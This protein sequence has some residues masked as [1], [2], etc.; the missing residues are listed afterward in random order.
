MTGTR[1]ANHGEW[2]ELAAGY[3]LHALEPDEE[4]RF[5]DHLAQC[6]RCRAALA[7]HDLVA[8]QLGSLAQDESAAAPTWSSLRAGIVGEEP[9][10]APVADLERRRRFRRQ[11][12]LLGAAAAVVLAAGAGIAVWQLS[13]SGSSAATQAISA[14]SHRSGCSVV[15]LHT[16][17]GGAPAVVL[18]SDGSAKMVPLAMAP[19]PAGR[20]YVLWQLLR[21]GGPTAVATFEDASPD[22]VMPLAMPYADTAAFAVS[23]EP[24]G[25]APLQPTKVIA[26]GNTTT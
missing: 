2:E 16:P 12:R 15:R 9:M 22:E 6:P 4:R 13:G 14:C 21:N 20:Q 3:A 23:V 11:T 10:R 25:A 7:E 26:V 5:A 18:V 1:E 24:A 19:A 8:A 17:D